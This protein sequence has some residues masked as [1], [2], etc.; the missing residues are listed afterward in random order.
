VAGRE[1]LYDTR[2]HLPDG[3]VKR[4][5]DFTRDEMHAF[6]DAV[7]RKDPQ[8]VF[9]ASLLRLRAYV[10]EIEGQSSERCPL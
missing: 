4:F 10:L 9:D 5:G 2:V 3:T 6:M 8:A 1:Y 7:E